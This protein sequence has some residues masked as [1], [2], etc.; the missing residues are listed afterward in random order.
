VAFVEVCFCSQLLN[1]LQLAM[2]RFSN[3]VELKCFSGAP[4]C[5]LPMDSYGGLSSSSCVV[6][7]VQYMYTSCS[8][9]KLVIMR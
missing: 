9:V 4:F 8:T 3:E 1:W 5:L 2:C 7:C 6:I